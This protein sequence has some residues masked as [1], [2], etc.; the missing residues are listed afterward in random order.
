VVIAA[1]R[2]KKEIRGP[3]QRWR[4]AG[5]EPAGEK[6]EMFGEKRGAQ[7]TNKGMQASSYFTSKDSGE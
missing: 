1:S 3:M 5:Q 4:M 2:G 6:K 7:K